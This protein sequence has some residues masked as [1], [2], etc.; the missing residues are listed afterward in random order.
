M[1]SER[2][3]SAPGIRGGFPERE[4][5]RIFRFDSKGGFLGVSTERL[6]NRAKDSLNI[7]GGARVAAVT[8][9]S[10][11]EKAGLKEGDVILAV[12]GQKVFSPEDLSEI[13]GEKESGT[14]VE[15]NYL[16]KGK[17]RTARAE[18]IGR[19]GMERFFGGSPQMDLRTM[20]GLGSRD[21]QIE[22][23]EKQIEELRKSLDSL[24]QEKE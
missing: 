15:I 9:Q 7:D 1:L 19:S 24:R 18:L 10:P 8:P 17:P 23:L 14:D 3:E 4:R 21:R 22:D 20:P 13:V 2:T 16:R 11:A 12:D 5:M 6:S